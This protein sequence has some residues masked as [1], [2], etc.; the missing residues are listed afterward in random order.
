MNSA[1]LSELIDR[2][3]PEV[4]LALRENTSMCMAVFSDEKVLLFA[5]RAMTNLFKGEPC[6]SFINP[7]FDKLLSLPND[8][9]L[10]FE[11]MMT[12]GDYASV[13]TSILAQ[14]FRKAN[15]LLVFGG[16]DSK[17]LLDQNAS[18]HALN[19][20]IGDLQRQL[21]REKHALEQTLAKLNEANTELKELDATKNKFF[22]II[23]HDLKN[24]FNALLG[25]TDL[26]MNEF[27]NFNQ[28]EVRNMAAAMHETSLQTYTLLENL[29]EWSRLQTGK[30]NPV[31]EQIMP[32]SIVNE[33]IDQTSPAAKLKNISLIGKLAGTDAVLADRSM[34]NT[35]LRNL[36]TNAI[37]FTANNGTITITTILKP[38]FLEFAVT[39]TG[40][41]IEPEHLSNLFGLD[42]GLS[43][44][45]TAN[46]KGT[47][48]GLILCREFVELQHGNIW[49]ES[50]LGK[51][52]SFIFTLPLAF[53]S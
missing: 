30:L 38:A 48:L 1:D 51:G 29:L 18:M 13:N 47:G 5:N 14:V 44:R 22:S 24:P 43:K 27:S 9:P 19:R 23:A 53:P 8:K 12:I 15:Q 3:A 33:V 37:K 21:I 36:V 16:V 11:G 20:E 10:I 42:C 50:E 35:V 34:L 39:D 6:Q 32:D 49:V 40:I 45:G 26:M 25:L 52:S 2:W 46:E 7:V 28:D 4:E 31:I 17:Q 41:G